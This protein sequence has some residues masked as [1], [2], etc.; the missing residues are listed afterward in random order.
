[1]VKRQHG[2]LHGARN[3]GCIPYPLGLRRSWSIHLVLNLTGNSTGVPRKN[4]L[5][6]VVRIIPVIP[7][8]RK[9]RVRRI[10]RAPIIHTILALSMRARS[11]ME[12]IRSPANSRRRR[13]RREAG[14]LHRQ[15]VAFHNADINVALGFLGGVVDVPF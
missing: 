6:V 12:K 9:P 10:T 8:R 15:A 1:M 13:S 5:T 11:Q 14:A 3:K 4:G 7:S 2:S